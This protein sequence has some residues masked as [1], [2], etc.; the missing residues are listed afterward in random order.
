MFFIQL[1]LSWYILYL[2]LKYIFDTGKPDKGTSF[3]ESEQNEHSRDRSCYLRDVPDVLRPDI[4]DEFD[5]TD[6]L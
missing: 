2:V 1:I 4:E 5:P 6:Y 3:R